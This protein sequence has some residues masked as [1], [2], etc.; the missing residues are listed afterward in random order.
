MSNKEILNQLDETIDRLLYVVG[1]ICLFV[2]TA[3]RNLYFFKYPRL[4]VLVFTLLAFAF[5]LADMNNLILFL[6]V[7][8]CLAILYNH[9]WVHAIVNELADK[10]F[11]GR[12]HLHPHFK[13]PLIL[14]KG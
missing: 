4:A 10:F 5:L 6:V 13:Q 3:W 9:K 14:S 7:M 12:K 1:C 8:L 2:Q 11:T